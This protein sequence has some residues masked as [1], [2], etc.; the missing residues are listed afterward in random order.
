MIFFIHILF[1]ICHYFLRLSNGIV[2]VFAFLF[3]DVHQF[4]ECAV[5]LV[6]ALLYSSDVEA[7]L[8]AVEDLFI[9]HSW[10]GESPM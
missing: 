10:R 3:D 1:Y 6:A 9:L 5:I 2:N 7:G 4:G 8:F